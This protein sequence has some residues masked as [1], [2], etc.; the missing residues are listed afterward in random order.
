MC[1]CVC[2]IVSVYVSA[3]FYKSTKVTYF[4]NY[5]VLY[6]QLLPTFT[7]SISLLLLLL[8]HNDG[9]SFMAFVLV[10]GR[11]LWKCV[12]FNCICQK[13]S[14]SCCQTYI[15]KEWERE[16]VGVGVVVGDFPVKTVN[17]VMKG[18]KGR[19]QKEKYMI[20]EGSRTKHAMKRKIKGVSLKLLIVVWW[21]SNTILF[22]FS[23]ILLAPFGP[24]VNQE[25]SNLTIILQLWLWAKNKIG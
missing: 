1:G 22:D 9:S 25:F 10:E 17:R 5:A 4:H 18:H 19:E 16:R 8:Q 21:G 13:F 2:G 24:Q 20:I 12:D 14:Y 3:N 15:E 6:C 23:T 11:F 7:S